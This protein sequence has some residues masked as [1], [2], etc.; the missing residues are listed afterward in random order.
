MKIEKAGGH[1]DQ[2][3]RQT[4][5]H[6]VQLSTMADLKANMLLTM[7]SV[8]ITLTAANLN[9]PHL[10]WAGVVLIAFCLVT[11]GLAAFV[12]MPKFSLRRGRRPDVNSP[13]FNL[14]F[15][16]DFSR[17]D[18]PEFEQAM[19]QMMN[20]PSRAYEAQVREVYTLGIFLARR[21]YRYLRWAYL[22][23]FGGLLASGVVMLCSGLV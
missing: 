4:R 23:F 6:H 12:A 9:R 8:I 13:A 17:L 16:G 7:S 1:L 18:Y 5:Q 10:K 20:D 21:K 3:M 22:A 11:I 19:E 2:M 14:L 15:F